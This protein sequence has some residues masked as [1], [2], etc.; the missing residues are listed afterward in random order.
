ILSFIK[1]VLDGP[2]PA[3]SSFVEVFDPVSQ[4]FLGGY[5]H[6]VIHR[7]VDS[8][9][10]LPD[11]IRLILGVQVLAD[12]FDKVRS[13]RLLVGVILYNH[14]FGECFFILLLRN[15]VLLS[16][17]RKNPVSAINGSV[18]VNDRRITSGQL[19]KTR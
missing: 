19:D 10:A 4:R 7:C 15:E 9:T 18:E 14:F 12:P 2:C 1:N 8:Q 16:H 5:L 17:L 13:W 3:T 11:E 6:I